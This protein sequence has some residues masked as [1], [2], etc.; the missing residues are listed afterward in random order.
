MFNIQ[1]NASNPIE[2][3]VIIE[4]MEQKYHNKI[5][6][7]INCCIMKGRIRGDIIAIF[8]PEE[9]QHIQLPKPLPPKCSIW[10]GLSLQDDGV[11]MLC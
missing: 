8:S 10:E 2:S 7:A 5:M 9:Y 3:N 1:K 11:G 4:D 6:I